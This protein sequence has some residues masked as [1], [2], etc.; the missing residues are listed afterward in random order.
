[1][2]LASCA[3]SAA[4]ERGKRLAAD[5]IAL[6][7]RDAASGRRPAVYRRGA[8]DAKPALVAVAAGCG[9]VVLDD[10]E[11]LAATA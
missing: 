6:A 5:V 1:M 9:P 11:G 10:R 7:Y 8:D 3:S 4:R 2:G